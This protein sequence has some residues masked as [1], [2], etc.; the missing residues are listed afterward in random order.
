MALQIHNQ[1]PVMRRYKP[2]VSFSKTGLVLLSR[3][4]EETLHLKNGDCIEFANDSDS[5]EDWFVRKAKKSD[6]VLRLSSD[7]QLVC[8]G[9][10]ICKEIKEAVDL[11]AERTIQFPI[12]E[13]PGDDGWH[14]IVTVNKRVI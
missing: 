10:A 7:K 5:P 1:K 4:A 6:Y 11:P 8:N 2:F 3:Q 12:M 14:L 13:I 9:A